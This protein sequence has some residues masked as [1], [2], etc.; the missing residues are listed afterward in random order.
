NQ[1]ISIGSPTISSATAQVFQTFPPGAQNPAMAVLT[2][3]EDGTVPRI[4]T[5]G[6]RISQ[7]RIKI[8]AGFNM[9]WQNATMATVS[10]KLSSTVSVIDAGQTLLLTATGDF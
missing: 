7:L 3:R 2:I 4:G 6:N 9:V 1:T 10:G 8:P 5:T